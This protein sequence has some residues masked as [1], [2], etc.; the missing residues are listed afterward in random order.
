MDP[1]VDVDTMCDRKKTR[2]NR[3]DTRNGFEEFLHQDNVAIDVAK[4]LR[5][6]KFTRAL[7][8]IVQ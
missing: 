6:R 7:E 1:E 2:E 8:H 5:G 3:L 4:Q